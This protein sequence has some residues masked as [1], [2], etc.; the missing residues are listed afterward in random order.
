[1]LP[2][3]HK[4]VFLIDESP[5]FVN[6]L[7]QQKVEFDVPSKTRLPGVV[8]LEPLEKTL[9]TC[10][11]EAVSE[12]CRITWD[13]FPGG[14]RLISFV[15]GINAKDDL[16]ISWEAE[17]QNLNNAA[18][19]FARTSFAAAAASHSRSAF[20]SPLLFGL[21]VAIERL[22][23]LSPA[24]RMSKVT[25]NENLLNKGRIVCVS[26]FS[27]A[28][29]V[30]ELQ[31][32]LAAIVEDFNGS[33]KQNRSETLVPL[34][35][36]EFVLINAFPV[37]DKGPVSA[38]PEIINF[39]VSPNCLCDFYS[40][41][42]GTFLAQKLVALA[43]K[44]YNLASTTVT[45]IPM[46]EEQNASSSANYDVE[47]VHPAEAHLDIY[48]LANVDSVRTIKEGVGY[49]TISLKWCTPRTNTVE[50]HFT[51]EACRFTPVDVNSR[52]SSCL[53][54]FLLGGRAVM[55]EMPRAKSV[56]IMSHMLS[57][58]KH[59][60]YIHTLSTSR[61]ILEDPPSISEGTGGR[62]TDYRI[63]D[64]GELMK[65]N[66]LVQCK[67][68]S[69][70]LS[71]A[72]ENAKRKEKST[73]IDAA[74]SS[75]SR[76]SLYWP[77][78]IGQTI[79]YNIQPQIQSLLTLIPKETL[80]EEEVNE[81]KNAIYQ[82]ISME[83]KG[84]GLPVPSISNRAKGPKREELYKLLSAEIGHFLKCF[85]TTPEHQAVLSCLNAVH[86]KG[87]QQAQ[88]QQA[89]QSELQQPDSNP[90]LNAIELN[91]LAAAAL[92]SVPNRKANPVN[93]TSTSSASA[94]TAMAAMATATVNVETKVNLEQVAWKEF[95]RFNQM[96]EREKHDM[97]NIS[98]SVSASLE[99]VQKKMRTPVAENYF[100]NARGQESLLSLWTRKLKHEENSKHK[101]FQGR[102]LS[103]KNGIAELYP[104]LKERMKE[105]REKSALAAAS[106]LPVP[107][108]QA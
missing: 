96:T 78:V 6:T 53:T 5:N 76:Q 104:G 21:K 39:K 103:G 28:D 10:A 95:D 57:S 36:V 108:D 59:E 107:M 71:A 51:T 72:V 43:L 73:P 33:L 45:G 50:L 46:K 105:K 87:D 88:Q 34:S 35:Q 1:M 40:T 9:W 67:A 63:N 44:H 84:T 41:R 12:Y 15:S 14:D 37:N 65:R 38:V 100:S 25:Y 80:S 94:P 52:P 18:A 82:I 60:L 62:V 77:I 61:S 32:T 47:I 20:S 55:L 16:K 98:S 58:H 70:S 22:G 97:N 29:E 102:M 49:D 90:D 8:T 48:K 4:T 42:S 26:I 93:A 92:T 101:E 54:N 17:D 91:A 56:K 19:V 23:E 85:S 24:Q 75:L 3:S 83:N 64:F 27:N 69:S 79:M 13:I 74:L 11:I 31:K 106:A 86:S 2:V 89:P 30:L 68:A 7:S 99:P 66:K 81:C